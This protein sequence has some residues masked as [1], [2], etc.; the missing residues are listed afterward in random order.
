MACNGCALPLRESPA[1]PTSE[2]SFLS[3]NTGAEVAGHLYQTA[4]FAEPLTFVWH[5]TFSGSNSTAMTMR[6]PPVAPM[7]LL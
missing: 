1:F 4:L 3:L 2:V 5:E 7:V 6:E